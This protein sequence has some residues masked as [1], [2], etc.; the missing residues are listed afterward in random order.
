M[1]IAFFFAAFLSGQTPPPAAASQTVSATEASTTPRSRRDGVVCRR[2]TVM[3]SNRPR[4]VCTSASDRDLRRQNAD[5]IIE[6]TT[7][8]NPTNNP[9]LDGN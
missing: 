9:T 6:R 7:N 1:L 8:G 3:G 4:R 2:E 5:S